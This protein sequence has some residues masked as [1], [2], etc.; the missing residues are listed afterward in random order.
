MPIEVR[1]RRGK[2]CPVVVCDHCGEVISDAKDG[3]YEWH[4]GGGP[5][6]F[7]HK[8]CCLAFEETYGG[9]SIWGWCDLQCLPIYLAGNLKLN[10]EHA[11]ETAAMLAAI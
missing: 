1:E 6:F 4:L 5:V 2:C 11:K 10:W 7:T 3:N 9:R 8:R